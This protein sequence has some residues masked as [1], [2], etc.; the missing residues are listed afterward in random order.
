[1][2]NLM[3]LNDPKVDA[4]SLSQ[5][6]D[7]Y[8]LRITDVNSNETYQEIMNV[9]GL[10]SA[11]TPNS[12]SG[13]FLVPLKNSKNDTGEGIVDSFGKEKFML[14]VLVNNKSIKKINIKIK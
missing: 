8:S 13:N 7:V 1:M 4:L 10:E 5:N 9:I 6:G 12:D 11:L 3:L 14:E 2:L